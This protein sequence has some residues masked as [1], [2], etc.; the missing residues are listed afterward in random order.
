MNSKFY[1]T[2]FDGDKDS[3]IEVEI[4]NNFKYQTVVVK[5]PEGYAYRVNKKDLRVLVDIM[6]TMEKNA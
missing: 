1:L 5:T 2:A 3:K 4:D 6:N